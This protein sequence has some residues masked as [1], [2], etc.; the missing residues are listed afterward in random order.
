M[1]PSE[2]INILQQAVDAGMDNQTRILFNVEARAFDCHVVEVSDACL[3][4]DPHGE[5]MILLSCDD[6][7]IVAYHSWRPE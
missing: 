3:D 1:K 6:K 2:L 4:N 7:E 5:P